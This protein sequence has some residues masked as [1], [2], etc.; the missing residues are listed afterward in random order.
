M[1]YSAP[2]SDD[3]PAHVHPDAPTFQ[4]WRHHEAGGISPAEGPSWTVLDTDDEGS[5]TIR[6]PSGRRTY[7]I[8]QTR[9]FAGYERY[10]I[11]SPAAVAG[12]V[13]YGHYQTG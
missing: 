5:M 10:V 7:T 4:M 11:T 3:P 2:A 8:E 12:G 13:Q 1:G 9:A 6:S